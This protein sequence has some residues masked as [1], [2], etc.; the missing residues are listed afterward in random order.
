MSAG[1]DRD[2]PLE[3]LST[4]QSL[5]HADQALHERL[6]RRAGANRFAR[7][8]GTGSGKHTRHMGIHRLDLEL[9][10]LRCRH[11]SLVTQS[12]ALGGQ[13]GQRGLQPM[14]QLAGVGSG[15]L[16]FSRLCREQ[17]VE[18]SDKSRKL[19]RV[20]SLK[21]L[22]ASLAQLIQLLA[23]CLE[24]GQAGADLHP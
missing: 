23:Q 14:S 10:G 18:I 8:N 2:G 16:D 13:N 1:V 15:P 7:A 20:S 22:R 24:R 21:S 6:Q 5:H 12:P 17:A 19:V 11:L 9:D 3:L 4:R